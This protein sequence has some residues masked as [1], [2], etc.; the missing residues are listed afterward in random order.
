MLLFGRVEWNNATE[1]NVNI[2]ILTFIQGYIFGICLD[3]CLN[4]L[5]L[6]NRGC[7]LIVLRV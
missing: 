3:K 4:T 7:G 2:E 1:N 5:E 6:K